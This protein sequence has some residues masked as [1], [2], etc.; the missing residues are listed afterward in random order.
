MKKFT[1]CAFILIL[2]GFLSCASSPGKVQTG[3]SV[4]KVSRNGNTVFLGGSIHV[5]RNEDFPLPG[6][7]DRAFSQSTMLTLETDV[8]QL[9]DEDVVQY[10]AMRMFL[11]AGTTLKTILNTDT[12]DILKSKLEEYR[13]PIEGDISRLKPSMIMNVLAMLEIQR[14]GFVEQGVDLHYLEKAKEA[15]K[16]VDFLETVQAQI[17]MIVTMGDGYENDFVKYSLNDMGN[18]E[19][20]LASIVSE[21]KTGAA[22]STEKTLLEMRGQWPVIYKTTIADRNAAWLPK[23]HGYLESG[24]RV[25]IITGLAHLHGPDGLLRQLADSGCTVTQF[26]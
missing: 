24:S 23:I 22:A 14:Y 13:V 10:L 26:K 21:W 25:F 9:A 20:E 8:E 1:Y 7:F 12:Y 19:N 6:E 2:A 3:S 17:D 18:T 11:P 16:P 5:L 4:W 15:K